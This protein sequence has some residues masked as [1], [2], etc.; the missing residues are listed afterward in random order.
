MRVTTQMANESARKAGLPINQTSLLNYVNGNSSNNSLLEALN[1]KKAD[2]A[3]TVKM[4]DY[5]KLNQEAEKLQQA[6]DSL[7]RE[8][9][10]N[11][12]ASARSSGSNQEIC[13]YVKEMLDSYN[14]TLKLLRTTSNTLNNFYCQMM[15]ETADD[16]RENLESIGITF[17]KDGSASVDMEKLKAAD[18]D[19]LEK[20]FGKDGDFTKKT[21]FL[22]SRISDNAQ[23]NMENLSSRYHSTGTTYSMSMSKYDFRG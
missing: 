1:T 17:G 15:I 20:I 3:D 22:A 21:A 14:D 16:N 13:E 11:L 12:F 10:D 4:Q 8:G 2:A 18:I 9:E 6:A 7:L 19:T 23:A 5:E